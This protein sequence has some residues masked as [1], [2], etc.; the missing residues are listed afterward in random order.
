MDADIARYLHALLNADAKPAPRFSLSRALAQAVT[1][2]VSGF[3]AEVSQEAARMLGREAEQHRVFIPTAPRLFKRD[4]N[5]ADAP[6]G[7]Y[8]VSVDAVSLIDLVRARSV[9]AALGVPIMRAK[10]DVL[11][12]KLTS[13]AAAY[14]LAAETDEIAE[15]THTYG[16]AT[17]APRTCGAFVKASRRLVLQGGQMADAAILGDLAGAVAAALDAAAINGSGIGGEPL[18]LLSTPGIGG[19][20]GTDLGLA[21]VVELQT[22]TTKEAPQRPGFATTRAVAGLLAQRPRVS[23][24]EITLWQ[25][26]VHGG[27]VEGVPAVSSGS[28]PAGTMIFGDWEDVVVAQWGVLEITA[29]PF[30]GFQTGTIGFRAFLTADVA[31]RRPASFSVATSIT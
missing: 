18:G 12:P 2:N 14:W 8:L 23:G 1:G 5:A 3:E 21:G 24:G 27:T 25:G 29:D 19:V 10:G 16:A 15:G 20:T 6:S 9:T 28:M 4:L 31:V 11:M 30:T 22:D 17:L 26:P 13:G 7:G